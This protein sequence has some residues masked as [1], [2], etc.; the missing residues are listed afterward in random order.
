M[1]K[2]KLIYSGKIRDGV[3]GNESTNTFEVWEDLQSGI[4]FLDPMPSINYDSNYYR[5]LVNQND[6]VNQYFLQHDKLQVLLLSKIFQFIP[7]DSVI[8]DVGCG[9][10]SLLDILKGIS[11]KSIGIEPFIGYHQ[12]LLNRGHIVFKNIDEC[13][14]EYN[15]K[16][17]VVL[18]N[19]VIEHV[20]DPFDFVNKLSKLTKNSGKIIITTPNY[21]DILLTI[22]FDK[23]SPFF[24]RTVHNFYFSAK[25]LSFIA[26]QCNLKII[27]IFYYHDF[28]LSN[29][30]F[31]LRDGIPNGNVVMNGIDSLTE[32]YWRLY[33]EN[34]G[35]SN[36]IG[37]ILAK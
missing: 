2:D 12:S 21:F 10:G 18:S 13:L 9:G 6:D 32:Q 25:S 1:K 24:F 28:G 19:H 3:F 34:S 31:W 17:D 26:T 20:N 35:Q 22:N 33:L 11:L 4:V 30:L 36:N 29:T 7:R 5:I 14:N 16:C 23:F 15:E 8:V 37:I 27:K